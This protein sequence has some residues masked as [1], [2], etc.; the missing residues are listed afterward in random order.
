MTQLNT[1]ATLLQKYIPLPSRE[2]RGWSAVRGGSVRSLLFT[3]LFSLFTSSL[4]DSCIEP[5]LNLP[6]EEVLV[7]M[8][9][10]VTE[11]EVVWNLDVDWQTDWHYGWDKDDEKLWGKVEY[12]TPTNYEVRRYYVG[13]KPRGPH[14]AE[15]YDKF[16]IWGN[17][18][19]RTYEFG[20]YDLLLWSNIDSK[21]HTQVVSVDDSDLDEVT[22]TTT[23]TRSA[24]LVNRAGEED[25]P[26]ALY[27]Q[28][29]IFY[30]TYPRDIYISHNFEDY[31]YYDEKEKLW[32]K[33][34]NCTLTPLVY[35]YLVQIII[36]HNEDGRVK[37]INGD[38]AMTAMASRTSVN[39]GH[40]YNAPCN[41][42]FNTRMKKNIMVGGENT[43]IIGG[44]LTT[45]GLCD[46]D[47]YN[48]DTR[49]Q[50][51]GSRKE[52]HNYLYFELNMSGGSVQ[53]LRKDVTDQCQKQC[54]GGIITV[55]LDA[56]DVDDP[57]EDVG[58]GSIFHPTVEDYDEL[59]YDIPM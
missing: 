18:F 9:I 20:Y 53:S 2:G 47:G 13:E 51:N 14:T 44:K 56:R 45:Y 17:R 10:I 27:N 32:V 57:H 15:G 31:D 8:P 12:P 46:M 26:T 55:H 5:P 36:H 50:Y 7:E 49:A 1:I 35:I 37:S 19:R 29:E 42:Y 25:K 33:H 11:M 3:L 54:H 4:L 58:P 30:S 43:D 34:I 40:T 24:Q 6:A 23:I 48:S 52:L 28:P 21:D 16:T 22:A 41:V 59:I 39:T 38:C